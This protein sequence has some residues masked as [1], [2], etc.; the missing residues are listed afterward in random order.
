VEHNEQFDS[1]KEG[2]AGK[3]WWSKA[4]VSPRIAVAL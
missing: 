4:Q 2:Y 1:S 3:R